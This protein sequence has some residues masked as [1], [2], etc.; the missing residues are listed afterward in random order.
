V[1]I[2]DLRCRDYPSPQNAAELAF[3][4]TLL[5]A[6]LAQPT[7]TE[8]CINRPQQVYL[9]GAHGW[10]VVEVPE[11]T[12]EWTLQLAGLIAGASGQ[13][14]SAE[15]PLLSTSLPSGE[16]IQIVLPPATRPGTVAVA[17]RR[18]NAR[19]WSLEELGQAGV[20]AQVR[21]VAASDDVRAGALQA[22]LSQGQVMAFLR[23]A[24][25]MRLN[26]VVS[27]ATGSGKTTLT[28]ALVAEIAASE[29]LITIEDAAELNLAGHPNSVSL[30]YSKDGQGVARVTPKQLLEACLRLRPDRI[31]LAELRSEEAYDYLRNVNSGHPGSITSVHAASA[32][33]AFEQL[34]LLVKESPSGRQLAR[35]D[36]HALL[37]ALID[38]V[39]Q[40]GRDANG[41][42]G[43][44]EVWYRR[45]GDGSQGQRGDV[46]GAGV[47]YDRS[48]SEI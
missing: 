17:I 21:V 26:I 48:A 12:F 39:V 16:R 5:R 46:P 36:I 23:E 27:G 45:G 35:E 19:V 11:L 1:Q 30:F 32:R 7:L 2:S 43:V 6:L 18:P 42:L 44:V 31:L 25:R 13:T 8:L 20:F 4:I 47:A 34:M 33:L 22:L 10:Q 29:R 3:C 14:V 40:C 15:Q 28:K 41:R 37:D 9:E 24:V 38:V